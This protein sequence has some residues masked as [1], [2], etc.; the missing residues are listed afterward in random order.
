M[1]TF[2]MLVFGF[3]L[4]GLV[5]FSQADSAKDAAGE[6]VVFIVKIAAFFLVTFTIGMVLVVTLGMSS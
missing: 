1:I 6:L 5:A 3:V 2:L 4:Y